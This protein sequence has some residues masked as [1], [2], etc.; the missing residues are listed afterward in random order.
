M[1]LLLCELVAQAAGMGLCPLYSF[2]TGTW[3]VQV[4]LDLY[5]V[6]PTAIDSEAFR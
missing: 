1:L 3:S 4:V 5:M 2:L 6:T